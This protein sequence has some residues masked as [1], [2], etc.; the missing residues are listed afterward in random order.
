MKSSVTNL[1]KGVGIVAVGV[2]MAAA[3]IY[4][5]ETDDPPG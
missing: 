4:V 1:A 3:G 2:A 5:G